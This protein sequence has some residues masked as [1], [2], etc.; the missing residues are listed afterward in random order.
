VSQARQ[1]ALA[2]HFALEQNLPNEI[3]Y[4]LADWTK[5]EIRVGLSMEN[6]PDHNDERAEEC[7]ER[8]SKQQS[9]DRLFGWGESHR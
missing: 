7:R 6:S 4:P 1:R 2:N 5:L 3:P 8:R 9:E